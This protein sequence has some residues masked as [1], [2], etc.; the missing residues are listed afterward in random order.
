MVGMS[1]LPSTHVYVYYMGDY[2]DTYY[3]VMM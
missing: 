3:W 1:L 2:I